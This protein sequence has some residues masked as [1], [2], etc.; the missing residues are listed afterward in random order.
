[1]K[2]NKKKV[3]RK[4]TEK[5]KKAD[6]KEFARK[7]INDLKF[8][9]IFFIIIAFIMNPGKD[10][11]GEGF[12]WNTFLIAL[13]FIALFFCLGVYYKF[14]NWIKYLKDEDFDDY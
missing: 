12:D 7:E 11:L 2:N 4:K 8:G 14:K 5:N 3:R 13:F 1:V 10:S 6:F 9:A